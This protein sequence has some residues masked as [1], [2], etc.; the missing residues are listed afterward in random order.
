MTDYETLGSGTVSSRLVVDVETIDTFL[1]ATI[2]QVCYG[3]LNPDWGVRCN[4]VAALAACPVYSVIK[5]IGYYGDDQN[6]FV[7]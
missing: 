3:G 7:C 2:S 5:P 1:G 4:T 6:G